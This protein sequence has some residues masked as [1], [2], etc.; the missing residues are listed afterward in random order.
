M[1]DEHRRLEFRCSGIGAE[2]ELYL[3]PDPFIYGAQVGGRATSGDFSGAAHEFFPPADLRVFVVGLETLLAGQADEAVLT[4]AF[5]PS[6]LRLQVSPTD[7]TGHSAIRATMKS[8]GLAHA[9]SAEIT[10]GLDYGDVLTLARRVQKCLE[11]N[12]R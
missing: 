6:R 9:N 7:S 2:L 8:I 4:N 5:G 11:L 3:D 10:V 1:S 12:A